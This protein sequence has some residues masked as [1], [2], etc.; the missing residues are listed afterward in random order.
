VEDDIIEDEVVEDEVEVE[1]EVEVE[2]EVEAL[3]V[4][5]FTGLDTSVLMMMSV[6]LFGSG[7]YL[8]RAATRREEG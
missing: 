3:V 2:D 7:L 5:P 6:V 4:L 8:I 1:V